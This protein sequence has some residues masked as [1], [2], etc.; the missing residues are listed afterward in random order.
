M[1]KVAPLLLLE[2]LGEVGVSSLDPLLGVALLGELGESKVAAVENLSLLPT[3]L[4]LDVVGVGVPEQE[5]HGQNQY[6]VAL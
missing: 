3:L 6:E 5:D 2:E 1:M 4:L